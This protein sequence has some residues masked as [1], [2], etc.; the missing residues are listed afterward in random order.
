MSQTLTCRKCGEGKP[1]EDFYPDN[2]SGRR[3]S[4]CVACAKAADKAYVAANRVAHNAAVRAWVAANPEKHNAIQRRYARNNAA[5]LREKRHTKH[6]RHV[7][8]VAAIKL[9]AGC[10]DCGYAGHAEAL[11]FDHLPGYEKLFSISQGTKRS[12]TTVEAEIAKC[13]VVCAVCHH[14]RTAKRRQEAA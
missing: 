13:E 1:D 11:H 3:R 7:E 14:V 10:A 8:R 6:A 9:A 12:W 5:A 4:Q 2:R